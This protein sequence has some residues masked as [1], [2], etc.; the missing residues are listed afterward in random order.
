[1]RASFF[2]LC[3]FLTLLVVTIG[4]LV[5]IGPGFGDS[6]LSVELID[7]ST[8]SPVSCDLPRYPL[9]NDDPVYH[10]VGGVEGAVI[11][12]KVTLCGGWYP[13]YYSQVTDA[14]YQYNPVTNIWEGFPHMLAERSEARSI[15]L[16]DGRWWMI[17]GDSFLVDD[18]RV[19]T[20][21]ILEEGSWVPGPILPGNW[22]HGCAAQLGES[23]T[24][25]AGGRWDHEISNKT[26]LYHWD[27]GVFEEVMGLAH[28]KINLDCV[29]LDDRN[30][31]VT[32]GF[33]YADGPFNFVEIFNL[34]TRTWTKV[35]PMPEPIHNHRM[36][37]ENDD[38]LVLGGTSPGWDETGPGQIFRYN[39]DQGWTVDQKQTQFKT[40]KFS[41]M[42]VTRDML[43]C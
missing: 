24:L 12:D 39:K 18:P 17:A 38:V 5:F 13:A 16:P 9:Y 42:V 34:D 40:Y 6:S 8:D 37:K 32:G 28:P 26:W 36:V 25:L 31:M 2:S 7:F 21:E 3:L 1:M 35:D 29:A 41:A 23:V 4:D 30:V 10:I 19:T 14:C 43:G 27:T 11:N 15:T 20:T 33:T 22:N